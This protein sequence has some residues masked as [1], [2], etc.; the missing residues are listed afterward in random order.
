MKPKK[1]YRVEENWS[2]TSVSLVWAKS[3]EEAERKVKHPREGESEDREVLDAMA[4]PQPKGITI[5]R[6]PAEDR[7]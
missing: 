3:A 7:S 5:R 2:S 4:F 1:A 6:E